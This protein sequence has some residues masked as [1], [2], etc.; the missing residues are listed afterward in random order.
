MSSNQSRQNAITAVTN[1]TPPA[2]PLNFADTKPTDLFGCNVFNDKV[3]KERLPKGI[4]KSLRKT[5]EKGE[6]IDPSI[7][8]TVANAMKE[9]AIGK[10]RNSLYS[11]ILPSYRFNS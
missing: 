10:R 3:M 8:D 7:A 5:I 1:Y 2:T 4:Y 6:A 9:W 11:C